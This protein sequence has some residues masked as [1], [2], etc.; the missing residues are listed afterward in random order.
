MNGFLRDTPDVNALG[1]QLLN[2]QIFRENGYNLTTTQ[3]SWRMRLFWQEDVELEGGSLGEPMVT[4]EGGSAV[5]SI[6]RGVCS[7]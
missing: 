7:G 3:T 4:K 1:A 5:G 2:V 6:G